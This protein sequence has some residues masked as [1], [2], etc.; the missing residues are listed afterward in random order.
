[1]KHTC[2]VCKKWVP[3]MHI[4]HHADGHKAIPMVLSIQTAFKKWIAAVT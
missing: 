3:K 1:M 2:P 4:K